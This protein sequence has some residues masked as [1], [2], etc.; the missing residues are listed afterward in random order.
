MLY[1]D[2]MLIS[3]HSK[4]PKKSSRKCI[5][6]LLKGPSRELCRMQFPKCSSI[7]KKSHHIEF[8]FKQIITKHFV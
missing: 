5:Y 1:F 2:N 8:S 7:S 4:T 6:N 3:S